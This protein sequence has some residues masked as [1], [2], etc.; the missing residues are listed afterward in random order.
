MGVVGAN[1]AGKSTLLKILTGDESL[2]RGDISIGD[3]VERLENL[4]SNL[5]SGKA[6]IN[7]NWLYIKISIHYT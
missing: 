3:T 2:T 7:P 5:V 6:K 1:G 4:A